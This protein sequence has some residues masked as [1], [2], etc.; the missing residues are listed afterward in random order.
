MEREREREYCQRL[1]TARLAA[2]GLLAALRGWQTGL[3]KRG[4]HIYIY[5][6]IYIYTHIHIYIYIYI[7][8]FICLCIVILLIHIY[9]YIY[10][11]IGRRRAL[12]RCRQVRSL[13]ALPSEG[14]FAQS[15][16]KEAPYQDLLTQTFREIPYGTGN[17]AP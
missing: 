4:Y 11:Y 17:S 5:I 10:I 7:V 14:T 13:R 12:P 1:P 3:D 15:P 6:Y 16:Y 2:L 9:I 8:L